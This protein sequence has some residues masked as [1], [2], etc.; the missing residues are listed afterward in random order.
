MSKKN[1][2]ISI[3]HRRKAE[4]EAV[5][6]HLEKKL[7]KFIRQSIYKDVYDGARKT[8]QPKIKKNDSDI[9]ILIKSGVLTYS[10]KENAFDLTK[11]NAGDFS[12]FKTY[13]PNATGN[14]FYINF[15]TLP[16]NIKNAINLVY[17]NANAFG[18]KALDTLLITSGAFAV[19]SFFNKKIEKIIEKPAEKVVGFAKNIDSQVSNIITKPD[20]EVIKKIDY[21][22]FYEKYTNNL[23]IR[24][25]DMSDDQIAT[26]RKEI[27]DM[28]ETGKSSKDFIDRLKSNY[29]I[30]ADRAKLIARQETQLALTEYEDAKNENYI[31]GYRWVH[32]FPD[33]NT[34]RKDHVRFHNESKDGRVFT[35]T[36]PA[37]NSKSNITEPGKEINCHCYKIYV[38]KKP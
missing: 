36:N 24:I 13:F 32:P 37:I 19:D 28:L 7:L 9:I 1:T 12:I 8:E 21:T 35:K 27:Q 10:K 11:L 34:S 3:T 22:Q 18:T 30:T 16:D 23:K 5:E 17:E 20:E 26:I 29:S 25:K 33:R 2:F 15:N 6:E 4:I 14:F 38:L 31:D